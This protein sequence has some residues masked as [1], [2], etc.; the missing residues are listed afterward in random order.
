MVGDG[1]HHDTEGQEVA[2]HDEDAKEELA[3]AEEFTAKRAHQ[4]FS[5]IGEVLN[6]GVAF[7]EQSNVVTGVGRENS[8]TND[9]DDGPEGWELADCEVASSIRL[10]LRDET[11]GCNGGG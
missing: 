4:D 1:V 11:Q 3:Q 5:R 7:S 9:E 2:A 6:V 10:D 8:E